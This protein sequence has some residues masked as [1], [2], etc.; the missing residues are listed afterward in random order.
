MVYI[1]PFGWI[2]HPK[3]ENEEGHM[4]KKPVLYILTAVVIAVVIISGFLAFQVNSLQDTINKQNTEL[5]Q[6]EQTLNNQQN[7]LQALNQTLTNQ[8]QLLS[9]YNKTITEQNN[10]LAIITIV[11]DYGYIVNLTSTPNRIISLAPSNT[12]ILFAVGAGDQV[13]GVTDYCDYPYN[14]TAWIEAGNMTSIGNYWHPAIE[15]IVALNPDLILASGS[16]SDEAAAK[17]RNLGYNVLVLD[18]KNLN[19]VLNDLYIV[20]KATG[21]SD[22]AA[23]LVSSYRERIDTIAANVANATTTPKLYYETWSD[24]LMSA[25]PNTFVSDLFSIAGG[26]NIF[27]DAASEW[28]VVSSDSVITKNPD[29]IISY[30]DPGFA[31]RAGWSSINAIKNNQI[32]AMPSSIFSRPGP[33]LVDALEDLAQIIHPEIFGTYTP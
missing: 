19:G 13:V 30:D 29:I 25:G 7:Q 3:H 17:L 28:P 8:N 16:A 22:E 6:Y 26:A 21:H 33:R 11:D 32:Y 9:Q 1:I 18:A 15:P 2:I 23:A 5:T 14:F 27:D 12:E 24:P 31:T 10:Q 4:E 20:G